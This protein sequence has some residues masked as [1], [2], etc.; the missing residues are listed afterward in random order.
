M[1]GTEASMVMETLLVE[2]MWDTMLLIILLFRL[3]I[4]VAE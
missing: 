4:E 3:V 2:F 1:A